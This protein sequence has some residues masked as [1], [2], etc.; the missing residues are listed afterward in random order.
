[1]I[2]LAGVPVKTI[3]LE[4]L[5]LTKQTTRDEDVADRII[6]ERALQVFREKSKDDSEQER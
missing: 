5:L 3:N 6:I 4:G 1:M 2:D